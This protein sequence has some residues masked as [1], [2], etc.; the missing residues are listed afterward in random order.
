MIWFSS[1]LM[2]IVALHY[3]PE[4]I[5]IEQK[6]LTQEPLMAHLEVYLYSLLFFFITIIMTGLRGWDRGLF[7][8][9]FCR[10]VVHC[11]NLQIA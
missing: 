9:F 6:Y 4:R 3:D 11:S 8:I 5:K 10:A 1:L 7:L 2:F